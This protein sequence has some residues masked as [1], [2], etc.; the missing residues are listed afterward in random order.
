[1]LDFVFG[2][3][4]YNYSSIPN[5]SFKIPEMYLRFNLSLEIDSGVQCGT[6]LKDELILCT[7]NPPS[8]LSLTWLGDANSRG[9]RA[10]SDLKFYIDPKERTL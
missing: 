8:L 5:D 1:M 4:G 7:N 9:T 6:G 2:G 3:S 10:M